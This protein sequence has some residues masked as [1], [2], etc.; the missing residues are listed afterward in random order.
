MTDW[1]PDTEY[2]RNRYVTIVRNAFIGSTSQ[3]E[4]EFDRW[5]HAIRTQARQHGYAER[6]ADEAAGIGADI[7]EWVS[8][9]HHTLDTIRNEYARYL[10]HRDTFELA[11]AV[12][13]VLGE[14]DADG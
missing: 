7:D 5:L 10:E 12:G 11:R 6:L 4:A 3:H 8:P 13:Q 14:R 2:V 1:T 9:V